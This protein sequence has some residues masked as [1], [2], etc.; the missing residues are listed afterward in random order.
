MIPKKRPVIPTDINVIIPYQDLVALLGVAYEVAD[1]R[2]E[3]K[4]CRQQLGA[5]RLTF[6]EVLEKFNEYND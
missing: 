5:L 2:E 4:R 3:V 6:T 1:L